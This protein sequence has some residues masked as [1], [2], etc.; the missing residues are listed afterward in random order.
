VTLVNIAGKFGPNLP[1][2]FAISFSDTPHVIEG[3]PHAA[4]SGAITVSDAYLL[5][6]GD[7]KRSGVDLILS[8]DGRELVVEDYFKGEKRASLASPDGHHLTGDIV[9]ALVGHVEYAQATTAPDSATVIGHVTKLS[10][11]ATVIRNGVSI[12][13]NMGD[14]VNKGDVVQSGSNSSLGITF[15]DGTVFGLSS[16]AR[17]VLN[18]MVYDPNGSNNSSLLSLV[19]GTITFVAGETAKHGDMKVD[20]P[21]ATLGI[22]GTAVLVDIDFQIP[23]Q[24]AAPPVN[25]Q[26]L[27]EPDGTTGSYVLFSKPTDGSQ[28]VIIGTVNQSGQSYSYT[29][30]QGFVAQAAPPLPP[31][32]VAII[33]QVFTEKFQNYTPPPA[34][35]KT[36]NNPNPQTNSPPAGSTPASPPTPTTPLDTSPIKG[37]PIGTT[38]SPIPISITVPAP[39]PDVPDATKTLTVPVTITVAFNNATAAVAITTPGGATNQQ[40]HTITGT[41]A[42][43]GQ[44]A[45]GDTVT[46]VDTYNG[47][48]KPLGT[49]TVQADGTWSANNVTLVGNG[50]HSIVAVD[51]DPTGN[52]VISA[53]V[54]FALST[55]APTVAISGSGGATH[56]ENHT[57]SGTVSADVTAPGSTVTLFD[58]GGSTPIGTAIVQL[59]G[60]WTANDVTLVGNGTHSI[61]AQDIDLAGNIGTSPPVVFTL[62]T[63]VPTVAITSAGGATNQHSNTITGL[64]SADVTAPGSTVTLFDN[65]GATPIGTAIVQT[66]GT[67]TANNVTLVGNGTHSIVAQDIDLAGNIGTSTPVVF[68]LET[69]TPTVVVSGA[70]PTLN[71][72]QTDLI[73]FTFSEA[74]IGFDLADLSVSGGTL[75]TI[76]QSDATHYT[77]TFTPTVG[78][79]TAAIQV[80][81]SGTGTSSWTDLAGNPGA[82]SN[83]FTISENTVDPTVVVSGASPTLNASQTD[84]ITFTFSE[85]P[86]GFDL[87]DLSVSG[88]TL[89]T[90]TQS[91]ATHYTATFTPTVGDTTAAIQVLASGTGTSS[92]TDLAGNPGA[93][94][95]TLTISENNT[96]TGGALLNLVDAPAQSNTPFALSF[97][98]SS[99]TT[100]ISIEGYQVPSF[101]QTT[102]NG[103]FFN[104]AGPNLLGGT[105]TFTAAPSG[106]DTSQ[107]S[108]G[109]S[110][111]ALSFGG[112]TVGSYDVYSQ[113]IATTIGGVYTLDFLYSNPED[114]APSGLLVTTSSTGPTAAS[115]DPGTI[116]ENTWTGSGDWSDGNHWS[117][118]SPP[119]PGVEAAIAAGADPTLNSPYLLDGVTLQNGG[120]IDVGV[121]SETTLSLDD[122][123][124]I[125]GGALSIDSLGSLDNVTGSNT[126]SAA[127]VNDGAIEV[128]GGTLILS[129]GLSGPGSV[130]VD[131]GATLELSGG[132]FSGPGAI[133]IGNGAT[134]ELSDA[135]FINGQILTFEGSTGTLKL[136]NAQDFNFT[137]AGFTGNGTLAGSDQIDLVNINLNSGHFTSNFTNNILTVSD[138]THTVSLN[139]TGFVGAFAFASDNT[140]GTI[141]YDPPVSA[142]PDTV[143]AV[144]PTSNITTNT[145]IA[146]SVPDQTLVGSSSSPDTFVFNFAQLG[147][148]TVDNF[149]PGIDELQFN[150]SMF[151]TVQSLLDA[152]H[153]DGHGNT[154]IALDAHDAIKLTGVVKAQ[155]AQTDFHIV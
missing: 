71:A 119:G 2:D 27:A 138:G 121:T 37:V 55:V 153:D 26:V 127:V 112:V 85:A 49:A 48:A 41:V 65:G 59:D 123:T 137:I 141:V 135:S 23:G 11:N 155:L 52:P 92:W 98:A 82:A 60:T 9:N 18:E 12:V 25:F 78:D 108:D 66:D 29:P 76:T 58:N 111:P 90:I 109:T 105:W 145:T 79:T 97:T 31:A 72:S 10:G 74:P 61:V 151:A 44:A 93:A 100:T 115:G 143:A 53:P 96:P 99:S 62:N 83:T 101:E 130:I 7:Y 47:V 20:T 77:A 91:D 110:V 106:S 81:A 57:I 154:V 114:N 17:M 150:S 152:T 38:S 142:I 56:Q 4:L 147:H 73:T 3:F 136:D 87:A 32:A 68:T 84:L 30:T 146:A 128:I 14:N 51:T 95:N 19:A 113:T 149:N 139:F 131:A 24:G 118:G 22:R 75:G 6:L 69:L 5:F 86:I 116:S 64:V 15:I 122:G 144:A 39:T 28:P 45:V 21:V 94:S 89:G 13:L 67:W 63:V 103:L 125:T 8:K 140:N 129:G 42:A 35:D 133:D 124:T 117:A 36:D 148:D 16:N 50:T 102:H 33:Q 70:S 54:V 88:G 40:T 126:V 104:D 34:P 132:S 120:L 43:T 80:L 134:L 107:Y 1:H 46:L